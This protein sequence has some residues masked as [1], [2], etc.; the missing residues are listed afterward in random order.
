M[1]CLRWRHISEHEHLLQSAHVIKHFGSLPWCVTSFRER[2]C[3]VHFIG[4][5]T[6][7]WYM[8]REYE[9]EGK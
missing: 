3:H 7:I 8:I 1:K 5:Y 9:Y 6:L 2:P 4:E